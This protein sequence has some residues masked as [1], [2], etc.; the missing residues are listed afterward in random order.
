M[1]VEEW[2][3][4]LGELCSGLADLRSL[5]GPT[6]VRMAFN[7]GYHKLGSPLVVLVFDVIQGLDDMMETDREVL[8]EVEF[9]E[10]STELPVED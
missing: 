6:C 1:F 3:V 5:L 9:Q 7:E 8:S 4:R 10:W 2:D